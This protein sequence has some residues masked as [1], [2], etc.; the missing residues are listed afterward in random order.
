MIALD[1]NLLI[2]AHRSGYA[3]HRAASRAVE[4]AAASRRGWAIP[5]P[6][7]VEF[8]SVVTHPAGSGRPSEPAEAQAFLDS[9][10][11]AGAKLLYPGDG[12]AGRLLRVACELRIQGRRIFDLQIA[13]TAFEG[14]ASEIWT[15]DR[16]FV[17]LPG[18]VARDPL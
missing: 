13:L 5:A 12:F 18:L 6:A 4:K 3:E 10:L 7:A 14:G 16:N 9:L 11:E 1:S 8:Y 17:S 2:Y 15:H